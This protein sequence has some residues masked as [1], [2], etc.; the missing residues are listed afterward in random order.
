MFKKGDF[1]IH[2]RA[3]DGELYPC[4]IVELAAN[5]G[6]D[7]IALTD[8]NTISGVDEAVWAGKKYGVTVIP[9]VELSTRYKG[10]I[11]HI[12]G[13]FNDNRYKE[14]IFQKALRFIKG[15]RG[16][17]AKGILKRVIDIEISN[18]RPSVLS[19]IE[20]LKL[21]GAVVVLAHPVRIN[22]NYLTE[23]LNMPFDG[24][25]AKYI[26]NSI[27][28]TE[29]FMRIAKAMDIFYTAG[30]DFH[31]M[32]RSSKHGLIG[33]VYLDAAEINVFLKKSG[34]VKR[35]SLERSF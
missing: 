4:D 35:I 16:K 28:D 13:Y 22:K 32:I 24:I 34:L 17:D 5:R 9:G 14:D 23:V 26:C 27:S 18:G 15:H 8:H 20:L 25:E 29:F 10:E 19:G 12:L 3:S 33:D 1:H 7:I 21:F 11:I 2:S 6:I 31:R 30:S